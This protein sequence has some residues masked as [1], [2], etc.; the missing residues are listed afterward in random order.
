MMKDERGTRPRPPVDPPDYLIFGLEGF[1]LGFP[2]LG[3]G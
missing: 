3:I 2:G 1:N